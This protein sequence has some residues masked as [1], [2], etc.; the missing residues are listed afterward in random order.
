ML[1][2]KQT[3][4]VVPDSNKNRRNLEIESNQIDWLLL[5]L[6]VGTQYPYRVLVSDGEGSNVTR[7]T[8]ISGHR[9]VFCKNDTDLS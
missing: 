1:F 6:S 3:H 5:S 2:C 9:S 4:S 8:P 7:P